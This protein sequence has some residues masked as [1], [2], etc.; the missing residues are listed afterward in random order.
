MKPLYTLLRR[1][2]VPMWF[3]ADPDLAGV[4]AGTT[5]CGC[6]PDRCAPDSA[7]M[8]LDAAGWLHDAFCER[9][10]TQP[11]GVSPP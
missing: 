4:Q 2:R 9:A 3:R 8:V 6:L 1:P 7:H 5:R 11:T 10:P